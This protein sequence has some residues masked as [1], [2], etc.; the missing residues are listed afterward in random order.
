VRLLRTIGRLYLWAAH[1]LYNEFAVLYD[2]ASWIVSFGH[3]SSWRRL[4][5][6]YAVGASVLEVGFG[7]GELLI[8]L[9]R[10]GI[11]VFGLEISPAMQ[12]VTARKL[13][14]RRL[15]V[16][17]V[18]GRVQALPFPDGYFENVVSTFPAEYIADPQALSEIGR[19]LCAPSG[20]GVAGRGTLVVIGLTLYRGSPRLPGRFWPWIPVDPA[21]EQFCDTVRSAGLLVRLISRFEG[22]ARLPVIIAER[23]Q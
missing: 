14:R 1:R 2:L 4:A 8:E 19:V 6:D 15:H 23:Q 18:R 9:T 13:D 12:R 7:T 21:V 3:W 17:R 20:T 11:P 10:R 22:S 5:L 16:P